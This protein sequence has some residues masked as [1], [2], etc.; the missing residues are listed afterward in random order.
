MNVAAEK[1]HHGCHRESAMNYSQ[2]IV[3]F[4]ICTLYARPCMFRILQFRPFHLVIFF[5][6]TYPSPRFSQVHQFSF[7]PIYWKLLWLRTRIYPALPSCQHKYTQPCVLWITAR[8]LQRRPGVC[9][10][11]WSYSKRPGKKKHTWQPFFTA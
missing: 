4:I 5:N 2:S 6:S 10:V 3:S 11:H 8:L 9:F 1:W 7:T